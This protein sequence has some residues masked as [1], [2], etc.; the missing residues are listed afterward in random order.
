MSFFRKFARRDIAAKADPPEAAAPDA[1][2][3]PSPD[4]APDP[5]PLAPTQIPAT[6][7]ASAPPPPCPKGANKSLE[8]GSDRLKNSLETGSIKF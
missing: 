7:Q 4:R 6:P 8:T 5:P 1:T 3:A 2:P